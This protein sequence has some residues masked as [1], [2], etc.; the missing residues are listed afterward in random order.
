M[1]CGFCQL[2]FEPD[3]RLACGG[4]SQLSGGCRVVCC[5]RCHYEMPEPLR[6]PRFLARLFG[7]KDAARSPVVTLAARER[8]LCDL[9]RGERAQIVRIDASDPGRA[10]KL[11]A[12][13]IL[14]GARVELE[15]RAPCLV[16]KLG[17]SRFALD[18]RVA[19]AVRVTA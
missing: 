17:H 8:S 5:P 12:L 4:C 7:R 2:E 6:L 15:R 1:T 10:R 11:L 18:E 16:V 9:G 13:G 14:P 3:A 19:S